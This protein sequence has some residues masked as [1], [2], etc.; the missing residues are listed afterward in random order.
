[1]L[2]PGML[3]ADE[4]AISTVVPA[5]LP[6]GDDHGRRRDRLDDL[7][8]IHVAHRLAAGDVAFR[9]GGEEHVARSTS[10]FFGSRSRKSLVNQRSI[11]P[12]TIAL[13]ALLPHR[14]D[15][16]VPDLLVGEIGRRVGEDQPVDALRR[17]GAEPH[18]DHAAHR[19]AAPVG[20][21]DLRGVEHRQHVAAEHL[22]GVG[23]GRHAGLAVAAP[24]VAHAGGNAASAPR[25]ARPTCAA[26]CRASCT[27]SA[28]A[29]FPGPRPRTWIGQ[30]FDWIV[31]IVSPQMVR[32]LYAMAF[33]IIRRAGKPDAPRHAWTAD[34]DGLA[35]RPRRRSTA[36][37]WAI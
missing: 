2:A 19:E 27:A 25:P 21:V 28:P 11:V 23:A 3:L 29:C 13:Q 4:F 35:R 9:L 32:M 15:A 10:I 8:V 14:L 22:H 31:G 17:V 36:R 20:L 7:A 1:M 26:W 37:C 12:P 34:F 33:A 16:A 5:I 18:A 24:V 6:A 30:P